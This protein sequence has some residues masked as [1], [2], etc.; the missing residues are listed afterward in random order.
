MARVTL[1]LIV[2]ALIPSVAGVELA[3]AGPGGIGRRAAQ[4]SA[5]V[6]VPRGHPVQVAFVGSSGDFPDYT[7]SFANAIHM[8]VALHPAIRGFRVQI[9][10]YSSPCF[11]GPDPTAANAT[12]ASAV[13]ANPQTTAVIGQFCSAPISGALPVYEQA[14]LVVVSG[15]ASRAGLAVY[16]P[17]VFDR[18]IVA[19][20]DS[21]SWY[22]TVKSLPSDL[23]WQAA[24]TAEFG[25]TP[26]D[27]AD[28]YFDSARLVLDRL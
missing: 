17:T 10:P 8:A 4:A 24:Y 20:P 18:T 3:V 9:N 11:S 5:Q 12:V 21:T 2:A 28:L 6:V 19:D 7:T 13:V 16:A 15:S 23:A 1:V 14:G 22:T 27:F 25:S 26:L